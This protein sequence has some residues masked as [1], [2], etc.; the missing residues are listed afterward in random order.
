[1]IKI[2]QKEINRELENYLSSR[3]DRKPIKKAN[4]ISEESEF[5]KEE[6]EFYGSQ[7]PFYKVIMD[8]FIPKKRTEVVREIDE[9]EA[10]VDEE[11]KQREPEETDEVSPKKGFLSRIIDFFKITYDEYEEEQEQEYQSEEPVMINQDIKDIIKLQ[12]KWINKLPK[13]EIKKFKE[14]EDFQNYKYIL[15]KYNLIKK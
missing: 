8:I 12:H 3:V 5:E 4:M 10:E 11:I 7:K 9:V 2:T 13:N 1:V 6:V 15:E 14:S